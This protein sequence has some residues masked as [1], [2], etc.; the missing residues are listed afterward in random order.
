MPMDSAR[1]T[2]EALG[3]GGSGKGPGDSSNS[4]VEAA[5]PFG[6][7]MTGESHSEADSRFTLPP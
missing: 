5:V 2:L 7:G 1:G 4:P 3:L 6:R